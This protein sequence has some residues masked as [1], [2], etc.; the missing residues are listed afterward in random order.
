[1]NA[2]PLLSYSCRIILL[3]SITLQ[4]NACE[5]PCYVC[6]MVRGR[7][8]GVVGREGV[9]EREDGSCGREGRRQRGVEGSVISHNGRTR[10]GCCHPAPLSLLFPSLHHLIPGKCDHSTTSSPEYCHPSTTPSSGQCDPFTTPSPEH[11]YP[12][13]T[14]SPGHCH[15]TNP[16]RAR[17]PSTT[18]PPATVTPPLIP[19]AL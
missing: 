9:F 12:F 4:L 16:P 15:S 2:C 3:F 19:R 1:M 14:P 7:K 17:H 10:L 18:H 5:I 8:G 13:S 6:V 11:C